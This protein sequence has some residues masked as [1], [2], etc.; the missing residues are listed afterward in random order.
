MKI[1]GDSKVT[2]QFQATIPRVVR[3]LL[4]LELGDRVVFVVEDDR[5]LIKKGMLDVQV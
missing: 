4:N 5:V 3:E 1:L 2:E